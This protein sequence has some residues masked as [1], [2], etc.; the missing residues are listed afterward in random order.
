M[1]WQSIQE[2]VSSK[3]ASKQKR[4]MALLL[5]QLHTMKKEE[6]ERKMAAVYSSDAVSGP[7]AIAFAMRVMATRCPPGKDRNFFLEQMDA[8]QNDAAAMKR[9]RKGWQAFGVTDP[10]VVVHPEKQEWL[11]R[12]N[13]WPT[14][15]TPHNPITAASP[16][17]S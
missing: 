4:I 8:A 6:F 7:L 11:P 15:H 5:L 17:F 16:S 13:S 1:A 12:Y 10:W 3:D 2:V 9:V 14:L